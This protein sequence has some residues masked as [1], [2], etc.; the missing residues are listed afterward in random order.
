MENTPPLRVLYEDQWLIAVDKPAGQMV[1]PADVPREDDQ[2]TMK[3][4]RDQIGRHVFPIHRLDRP[5]TGVLLFAKDKVVARPLHLALEKHEFQKTYFAVIYG[6]HENIV[7]DCYEPLK[8]NENSPS[9]EAHTTFRVLKQYEHP[10]LCSLPTKVISLIEV[11]PHSGRYHQIRRHLL[12]VGTP[13]VGDYR[14]AGI[15]ISD[16]LG[17]CLGTGTRMLLQAKELKINHPVT[18][19]E[20][21]IESPMDEFILKCFPCF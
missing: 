6:E 4:L 14:Y 21:I 10:A 18:H 15:G 8:K 1:H 12:H 7:W 9:K 13:I 20:L 19:D 3:I 5:T 16:M 17:E 11:L 2:V